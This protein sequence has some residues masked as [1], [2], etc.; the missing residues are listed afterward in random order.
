MPEVLYPVLPM[1]E[2]LPV[3]VELLLMLEPEPYEPRVP[4]PTNPRVLTEGPYDTGR[5]PTDGPQSCP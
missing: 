1:V 2:V 3:A 4:L 5:P